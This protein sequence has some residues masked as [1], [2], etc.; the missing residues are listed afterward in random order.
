MTSKNKKSVLG[1]LFKVGSNI[2]TIATEGLDSLSNNLKEFNE[3]FERN[4]PVRA[5]ER[6]LE[7]QRRLKDIEER[8]KK[9]PPIEETIRCLRERDKEWQHTLEILKDNK[10]K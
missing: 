8:S 6:E 2:L 7:R 4:A 9:L 3:E 1:N 10:P 5:K